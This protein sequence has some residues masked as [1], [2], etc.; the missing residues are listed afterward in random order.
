MAL[1]LGI[2]TSC[3]E[4]AASVVQD[5]RLILSNVVASQIALHAQYGGVFPEMAS[6]E[7]VLKIVPVI[8]QALRDAGLKFQ[9]LTAVAVTNGP[10]LAGSL[11]VGVNTAKAIAYANDLPLIGINHLEGHI[12]ANWL[13]ATASALPENPFPL[14]ALI[15]S[16]GHSELVLMRGHNDYELIGRTLDDAAGEA[17]DKVARLVGLGYPGGPAIQQAAVAGNPAA[18]KLPRAWLRGSY[19]FSFSGLK[20]AVLHTVEDLKRQGPLPVADIAASFQAA[21]TDVLIEKTEQAARDFGAK[22]ILLA[23]GVAANARLRER[24]VAEA[25]LPVLVPPPKLCIDNGAMIAAAAW[26]HI[27]QGEKSGLDLDVV[28]SLQLPSREK[29]LAEDGNAKPGT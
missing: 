20:T 2:E 22:Q 9:D 12:Y 15:V 18:V 24:M 4:T 17:F 13:E 3:D 28:P 11:L 16:G 23:G 21:I 5:G 19:N 29:R 27:R 8:E 10:G 14:I 25:D 26:W 1:I 7:H 6:R